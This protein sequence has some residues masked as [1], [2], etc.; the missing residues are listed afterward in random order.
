MVAFAEYPSDLLWLLFSHD[1]YCTSP[2]MLC[3]RSFGHPPSVTYFHTHRRTTA[4]AAGVKRCPR[5]HWHGPYIQHWFNIQHIYS[6]S[7]CRHLSPEEV[8][9]S[10]DPDWNIPTIQWTVPNNVCSLQ[11]PPHCSTA[12]LLSVATSLLLINWSVCLILH[13]LLRL[14]VNGYKNIQYMTI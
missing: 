4:R 12:R 9:P 10:V 14:T 8:R 1:K 11:K 13:S 6:L 5:P 7:P 3:C 2:V